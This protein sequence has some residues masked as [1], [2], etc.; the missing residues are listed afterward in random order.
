MKIPKSKKS[1]TKS[2]KSEKA[3]D[4]LLID[5]II[6]HRDLS[7]PQDLGDERSVIDDPHNVI[8]PDGA[9]VSLRPR[10]FDKP[11]IFL[12]SR[13][14]CCETAASFFLQGILDFI[15]GNTDQAKILL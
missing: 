8:Y 1:V 6:K 9:D 7:L 10:A 5:S 11:T 4:T 12:S 2:I 13:V 15:S 14:H 3:K